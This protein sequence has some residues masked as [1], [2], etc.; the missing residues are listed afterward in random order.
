MLL[1]LRDKAPSVSLAAY[2]RAVMVEASDYYDREALDQADNER[3]FDLAA[4]GLLRALAEA[5]TRAAELLPQNEDGASR[6]WTRNEAGLAAQVVRCS[7][8][9]RAHAHHFEKRQLEICNYLGRGLVE[10]T[11]DLRYLLHSAP[12]SCSS[13]SWRTR[14]A[15]TRTSAS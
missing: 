5:V 3:I 8:L 9:L 11:I 13:G 2:S 6:P 14:S 7:K 15:A 1:R 12:W 4:T 10:T